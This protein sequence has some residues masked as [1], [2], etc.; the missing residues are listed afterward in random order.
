MY[1]RYIK[2]NTVKFI[3]LLPTAGDVTYLCWIYILFIQTPILFITARQYFR[4]EP[5]IL[6]FLNIKTE[7]QKSM[8]SNF[9]QKAMDDPL[10]YSALWSE[11]RYKSHMTRATIPDITPNIIETEL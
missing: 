5:A 10:S 1:S 7:P 3:C 6:E 8:E 9:I 11:D 2:N 4:V